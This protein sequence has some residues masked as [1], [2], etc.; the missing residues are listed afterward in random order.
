MPLLNEI[1]DRLNTVVESSRSPGLQFL[2]L[3]AQGPLID[4]AGGW[5]DLAGRRPMHPSTTLMAYSLSKTITAAAI[6]QLVEAGLVTLDDP[7]DRYVTCNP[8]GPGVTLRRM[9]SHTAGL[10]NPIPL[11]WVHSPGAHLDFNERAALAGVIGRHCKLTTQPG[12]AFRYSNIGYWL[13]GEVIKTVSGRPFTTYVSERILR[14]LGI[15][16]VELGYR[17]LNMDNHARGYLEKY[18]LFNVA[19]RLFVDRRFVGSYCGR[20]LEILPHYVDGAAYGGLV[21][22][23]SGIGRFLQDQLRPRSSILGEPGI[24]NFYEQQSTDNGSLAPMSL[25]WHIGTLKGLRFYFKEGGGGGFHSLMRHYPK[26]GFA[27][28][29]MCNATLFNVRGLL[30]TT[31]AA[32]LTES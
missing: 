29:V 8:Y 16:S 15:G 22:T 9:L 2:A 12:A 4:Y 6:L 32:I 18:S 10:P 5:A 26:P 7:L 13:L 20:W 24:H 25:G 23:V 30:D 27:S 11:A 31:D 21:G 28:V 19:R 1:R 3:T 17:I 14:P